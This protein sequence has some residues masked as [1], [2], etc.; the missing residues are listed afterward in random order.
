MPDALIQTCDDDQ[1]GC[2][3]F[4]QTF[5]DSN[6]SFDFHVHCDLFDVVIFNPLKN[7]RKHQRVVD[8][9]LE[10][11]SATSVNKCSVF[12]SLFR[13]YLW[14]WVGKCEDD[15]FFHRFYPFAFKYS[16][17][18]YSDEYIG[19]FNGFLE[20]S[21]FFFRVGKFGNLVFLFVHSFRSSFVNGSFGIADNDLLCSKCIKQLCDCYACGTCS[22]DDN[23]YLVDF[24]V[25]QF[26][27]VN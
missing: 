9:V 7:S 16:R 2:Q 1:I 4:I 15:R 18:W 10:I 22:I 21:S 11:A 17:S 13:Q 26:K 12:L 20:W 19:S 25:G 27:C 14:H 8:L 23:F 24:F 6:G 5:W 3:L